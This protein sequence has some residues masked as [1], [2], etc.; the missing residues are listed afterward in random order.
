MTRNI[1]IA[2]AAAATLVA[3]KGG[4]DMT[5]GGVELVYEPS[6]SGTDDARAAAL[7]E[8]ARKVAAA[9]L[10]ALKI[11]SVAR[12]DGRKLRVGL[13][14]GEGASRVADAKAVLAIAGALELREVQDAQFLKEQG[15]D[16]GDEGPVKV[17][18][19]TW[20]DMN[21]APRGCFMV[22]AV[23]EASARKAFP[24]D[25]LPTGVDLV[26]Q[27]GSGAPNERLVLLALG[28]PLL[29][30]EAI[31][32]VR[33]IKDTVST[34]VTNLRFTPDGTKKLAE[35]T[36]RIKGKKLAIVID[37]KI[38]STPVML[39]PIENGELPL[40]QPDV[41]DRK[42]R[43]QAANILAAALNSGALPGP[44]R[45]EEERQVAKAR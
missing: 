40:P 45:L 43:E 18:R 4:T 33:A 1:V 14:T 35:V 42:A 34:P 19:E 7:A 2:V 11:P 21:G 16:L 28:E 29:T 9:R 10:T 41:G 32:S 24:K 12:V 17:T 39:Q 26:I 44:M 27:V 3:C 23:D 20:T 37:G 30:N 31:L 5:R 38:T 22:E 6:T 36:G 8:G 25:K 13:P 15:K